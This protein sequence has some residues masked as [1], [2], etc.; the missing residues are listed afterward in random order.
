MTAVAV[1]RRW[2][3][4][5]ITCVATG[6]SLTQHDVDIAR[7]LG[8]VIAIN[9]A[10]RLAPWADVLYAADPHWWKAHRIAL[11]K[12]TGLR[13]SIQAGARGYGATVLR[14]RGHSGL[15]RDPS[16]LKTGNNSGY[17]AINLAVHFGAARIVL[18]GYDCQRTRGEDHFFGPHIKMN[19]TT[20]ARFLEWR[21]YF[22]TLIKPLA[23]IGVEIVN[24]T[25]ET[26]LTCFPRAPLETLVALEERAS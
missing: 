24:A 19:Q 23:E 15:E 21:A 25:R 22:A 12:F 17:Q 20:D 5:T 1:E 7:R 10:Y 26:A 18:L 3:G 14:H 16:G 13:F 11:A 6:P 9:D 4:S 2:P 8:P